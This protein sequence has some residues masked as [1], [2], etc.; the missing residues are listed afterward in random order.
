MSLTA[1]TLFLDSYPVKIPTAFP[2]QYLNSSN[3]FITPSYKLFREL[4]GTR[5]YYKE[6][7]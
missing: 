1:S 5:S 7:V 6:L 3:S 2:M 4:V